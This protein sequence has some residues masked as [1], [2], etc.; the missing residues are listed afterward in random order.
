MSDQNVLDYLKKIDERLQKL[1]EQIAPVNLD[2]M[3]VRPEVG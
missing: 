2:K 1:E 3:T